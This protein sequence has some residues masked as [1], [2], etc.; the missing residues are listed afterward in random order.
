[1]KTASVNHPF[2]NLLRCS[3]VSAR[4]AAGFIA[5]AALPCATHAQT[6]VAPR[7]EEIVVTSSIIP[8]ELRQVGAA[9]VVVE[10]EEIALRGYQNLADTL[11]TQPGM[12]VSNAGG[13]GKSTVLR[14]RGEEHFRTLL[15]I[16]G[17]K[18]LDASAP[19]VAPSFDQLLATNDIE[20]VEILR[21][22]QGF[23]YG[24]DAGGV[25]NVL[26]S[27]GAGDLEGRFGIE[28]GEFDSAKFEGSLSGGNE[29]GDYFISA[30]DFETDG[31]NSQTV[32]TSGERDGADNTT[33]HAKLGWNLS[34][35]LRLQL[36]ARDI[37]ASAQ[38][39]ACFVP[40]T[41]AM[42]NDC[43]VTTQQTTHKLSADYQSE[44]FTHA[45]AYSGVDLERDNFSAGLAAF[46]AV[47]AIDRLEYTGSYRS[48]EAMTLVYGA[49]LQDEEQ[50]TDQRLE[51]SQQGYYAEYQGRFAE[52]LFVSAGARYDDNDDFGTHTSARVSAAFVQH[53]GSDR[54]LKYRAS[55]GTGFRAPSLYEI[56]YNISPFA[57]PPAA[58]VSL[59]EETSR[60]YDLGV[61]YD[62]AN[63]LH[64]EATY[65]DQDIDDEI[66][67]D[68]V[69][70]SGYLQ[71]VGTSTSTGIEI[72]AAI[73]LSERWELQ[74]NWTHN[75]AD[76]ATEQQR[77][78][79]PKDF[80]SVGLLYRAASERFRFIANYRLSRGSLDIGNVA[81]DD[82]EVL[83]LSG[84]FAFTETVEI[85]GRIE[86]A[87]DEVYQEVS[88]YE[89]AA[90]ALYAGVRFD[91]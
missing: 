30:T 27:R 41:F 14:M 29:R 37:D 65:F 86:N 87:T 51:R 77:L 25:V 84:A 72:A 12:A 47:G 1:M 71:S 4:R 69:N 21:G 62:T 76:D 70:F 33:L 79:R 52:R 35:A 19:Q 3:R 40:V 46:D 45:V 58:G 64:L 83:D 10:G 39:D 34:D 75:E 15:M 5:L 2:A 82:Y 73:P 63:G 32:D 11:R 17:I 89:T 28:H 13:P 59:A 78:R 6:K 18:A 8:T 54:S 57:F 38:F 7:P 60:G 23:I 81:L 91:F 80:G 85:F 20:R 24:A 90:R 44:R 16:D 43:A 9:M 53:L 67:F 49:D 48:S 74:G 50:F 42:V 88:G 31:F 66:L 55:A 56:S 36:V 68:L 61:E 26:T 22:P